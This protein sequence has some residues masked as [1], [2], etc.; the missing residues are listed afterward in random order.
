MP[1]FK[2]DTPKSTGP[3]VVASHKVRKNHHYYAKDAG[4]LHLTHGPHA[5]GLLTH[6]RYRDP[7]LGLKLLVL[8]SFIHV[9]TLC[10]Q[11]L[12]FGVEAAPRSSEKRIFICT[13]AIGAAMRCTIVLEFEDG[14]AWSLRAKT[15]RAKHAW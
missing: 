11:V 2:S 13:D 12:H 5:Q 14:D 8:G 4:S 1:Q 9:H 15:V 10:D 6:A 3:A 7:V